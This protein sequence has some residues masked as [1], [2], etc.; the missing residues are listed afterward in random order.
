MSASLGLTVRIC[1]DIKV[2]VTRTFILF[3]V[4]LVYVINGLR[5]EKSAK[6]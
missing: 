1:N 6:Q 3:F 5:P 2:H 4:G